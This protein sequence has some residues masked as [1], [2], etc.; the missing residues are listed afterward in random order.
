MSQ[1]HDDIL[2]FGDY[3]IDVRQKLLLRSGDMLP[4]APKLFETLLVL[5]TSQGKLVEKDEL[6]KTVWPGTF[7]EEGS[8]ARNVSTLRKVLGDDRGEPRYIETIPKRG[9]RFVA[10]VRSPRRT[11][12]A[13]PPEIGP[14]PL[15]GEMLPLSQARRR[16]WLEIGIRGANAAAFIL[17]GLALSQVTGGVARVPTDSIRSIAVLPLRNLSANPDDEFFAD[18]TTE[19]LISSLAQLHVVAVT[20]RTSVMRYK[21]T[22]KP[23]SD[24]AREL[25]V[26]AVVE[27]S[28]QRADGRIRITAQLIRT[29]TDT[30]MWAS[31]YDRDARDFLQLQSDIA[32]AII[33][34]IRPA[35][36]TDGKVSP[37]TEK[38]IDPA[39][40]EA[41]MLGRF[42][43]WRNGESDLRS[44]IRYFNRAT[45]IEPKYAEAYAGASLAWSSLANFRDSRAEPE[46]R[47][48]ALRA[49]AISPNLAE[50]YSAL[51]QAFLNTWQ[52]AEAD[53]AYRKALELDPDQ[54]DA[55]GCYSIF[56]ARRGR[57][58]E[59]L[60]MIE[61][62]R[63][64]I[65]SRR[66]SNGNTE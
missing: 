1:D 64:L 36:A 3:Q 8:L 54:L 48:A 4:L 59:A 52:W 19:S 29:S 37:P 2:E 30:H 18:G 34:D 63:R 44:A 25:N 20:S 33:H 45:Q 23:L 62:A 9:Y 21:S 11:D 31:E 47:S 49:I 39:A 16:S 13:T 46:G 66:R 61:H 15:G 38:A 43:Y 51:G 60:A 32:D 10:P 65:R 6:L 50:A 57:T 28:V 40:R 41:Y 53:R 26:D 12:P 35:I 5:V 55:C 14:G 7:V 27:G 24:I 42:H 56:L 22:T 58:A 17:M